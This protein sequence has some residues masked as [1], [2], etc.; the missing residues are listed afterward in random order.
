MEGSSGGLFMQRMKQKE[1]E[2]WS[3]YS[4]LRPGKDFTPASK[5]EDSDLGDFLITLN[6][7]LSFDS[8]YLDRRKTRPGLGDF[9]IQSPPGGETTEM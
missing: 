4:Q 1:T 9:L 2:L 3:H 5:L 6:T 7:C 8:A